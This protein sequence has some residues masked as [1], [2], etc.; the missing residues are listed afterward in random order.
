M[1][2]DEL[3]NN[4]EAVNRRAHDRVDGPFD[5]FR[6]S[7]L[8]TPVRIHNL[9]EGGCF[10]NSIYE[11]QRGTEVIL[12]IDLPQEEPITVEGETLYHRKDFG[13]GVRFTEMTQHARAT[14]E[15][16]LNNLRRHQRK[17]RG[18]LTD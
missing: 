8:D 10:V 1:D 5:G 4:R 3:I 12:T 15:R 11:Q 14:L 6:L 9:S 7:A 18:R 13:F 2:D 17:G 16:V